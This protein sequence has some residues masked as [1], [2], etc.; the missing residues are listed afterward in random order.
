MALHAR[1]VPAVSALGRARDAPRALRRLGQRRLPAGAPRATPR[2]SACSTSAI[3]MYTEDVD[4]CARHPRA[5]PARPVHAGRPRSSTCGA[6]RARPRRRPR[7]RAYRR[8]HLAFYEKHHPRWAPLLQA[9]SA[10]QGCRPAPPTLTPRLTESSICPVRIAIDARKLHDLR[11]RHLHP[12][13]AAAPLRGST[14]TTEYVLLCRGRGLRRGRRARAR[15]SAPSLEPAGH[16]SVRE[17]LSRPARRCGAS[18]STC[19]TR[20][21]TCCRR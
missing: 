17:Q 4:F 2:R 11:H 1:R 9:L 7:T 10:A 8:S 5:R 3:F 21:T 6:A 12:Q 14:T 20:R 15:T 16:Y 18:G 13:P 19:S